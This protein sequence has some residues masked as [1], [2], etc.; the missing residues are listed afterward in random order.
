MTAKKKHCPACGQK[1]SLSL[2]MHYLLWGTAHE[3][4]CPHCSAR[5][6]PTKS[7]FFLCFNLGGATALLSF[8]G[9]IL[10]VEDNFFEAIAFAVGMCVLLVLIIALVTLR[11]IRFTE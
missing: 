8:W 9:Y 6:H 3:I 10:Y 7:H 4:T 1:I 5:L 11:T 2:R